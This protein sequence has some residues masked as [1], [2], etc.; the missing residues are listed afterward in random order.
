M[1]WLK[2]EVK[3]SA[4]VST[5]LSQETLTHLLKYCGVTEEQDLA[6]IWAMLAK[7]PAKDHLTILEGK[8]AYEFLALGAVYEQYALSLFLLTQ[9]TSLK[10]G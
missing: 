6:P 10:W 1:A 8:V 2:K 9:V 7:A 3:E 5:W 4:T